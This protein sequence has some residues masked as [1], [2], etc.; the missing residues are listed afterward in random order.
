MVVESRSSQAA[1]DLSTANGS[2]QKGRALLSRGRVQGGTRTQVQEKSRNAIN[3]DQECV[4]GEKSI[5]FYWARRGG[6]K[7]G[8]Y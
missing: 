6:K 2:Q 1:A 3:S 8:T 7:G 4:K 5:L